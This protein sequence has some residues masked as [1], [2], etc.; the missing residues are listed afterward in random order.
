MSKLQYMF[1][2]FGNSLISEY[3]FQDVKINESVIKI[4][5]NILKYLL[6]PKAN[7]TIMLFKENLKQEDENDW[8]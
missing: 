6:T 1:G 5:K 4:F 3:L 7:V 8:Q 2:C